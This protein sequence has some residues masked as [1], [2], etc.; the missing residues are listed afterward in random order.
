MATRPSNADLWHRYIQLL[1]NIESESGSG[2]FPD[3]IARWERDS[4]EIWAHI[5]RRTAP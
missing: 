5:D 3:E 4:A 2:E 1:E